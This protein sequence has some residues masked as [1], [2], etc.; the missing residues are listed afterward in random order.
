MKFAIDRRIDM[1]GQPTQFYIEYVDSAGDER[2]MVSIV[3]LSAAES[4]AE[5]SI[6]LV[7]IG[8]EILKKYL[9][10][11]EKAER[12]RDMAISAGE[13]GTA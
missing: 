3:D 6:L 13:A 1:Q 11:E 7:K 10:H 8:E 12:E 4:P 9:E 2:A 5:A